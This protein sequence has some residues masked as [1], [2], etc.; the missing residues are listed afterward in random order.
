MMVYKEKLI[1]VYFNVITY[2]FKVLKFIHNFEVLFNYC[3][4]SCAYKT[5][6][7][8]GDT[9]ASLATDEI[10]NYYSL[11]TKLLEVRFKIELFF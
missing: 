11:S 3:R 6:F 2:H 7:I 4:I 10:Y 1:V 5:S 8:H 9:L